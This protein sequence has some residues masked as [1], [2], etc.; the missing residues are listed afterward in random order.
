MQLIEQGGYEY[1][2]NDRVLLKPTRRGVHVVGLPKKPRVNPGTLLSSARL[3]QLLSQ[4]KRAI[5]REMSPT[6]LWSVEDKHDVDVA[7]ALGA[8]ERLEATLAIAYSLEWKPSGTGLDIAPLE[9]DEA[10]DAMRV[11]AKDFGVFDLSLHERSPAAAYRRIARAVPF[12]RVRGHA[13]PAALARALSGE[14]PAPA[15]TR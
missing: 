14:A 12:Q 7:T 6:A 8:H 3:E 15:F 11:T 1:V 4:G 13:N 10:L 2:S 5:Y 9:A